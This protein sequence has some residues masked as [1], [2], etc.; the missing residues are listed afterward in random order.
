[1]QARSARTIALLVAITIFALGGYA[2]STL[3]GRRVSSETGIGLPGGSGAPPCPETTSSGSAGGSGAPGEGWA[4]LM[5]E[6]YDAS[7]PLLDD[8]RSLRTAADI[9]PPGLQV[10]DDGKVK[11]LQLV[12]TIKDRPG[13]YVKAGTVAV[14]IVVLNASGQ[15]VDSVSEKFDFRETILLLPGGGGDTFNF[16]RKTSLKI[17]SGDRVVAEITNVDLT[18][19]SGTPRYEYVTVPDEALPQPVS[20]RVP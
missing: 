5:V 20:A 13:W 18:V 15:K 2:S 9:S 11:Y 10:V 1:M 4:P 12:F 17:R 8:V 3:E 7:N 6:C 14:E 19:V 16:S